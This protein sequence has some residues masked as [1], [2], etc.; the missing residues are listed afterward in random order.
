MTPVIATSHS[1]EGVELR[2]TRLRA[3][4]MVVCLL[5]GLVVFASTTAEAYCPKTT[6]MSET[7][8]RTCWECM[9]PLSLIGVTVFNLDEDAVAPALGPGLSAVY[10]P[11]MCG[12]EC[13][14]PYL[15]VPGLPMG[16]FVADMV[17]DNPGTWLFHCHV[18]A[19]LRM[20]MQAF[21]IVEP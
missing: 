6:V 13:F 19:H 14:T 20:G 18:S 5:I 4:L 17:P 7:F 11:Q 15:C 9:F 16:M 21:F 8:S 12:C 3:G 1:V 2:T 10:P